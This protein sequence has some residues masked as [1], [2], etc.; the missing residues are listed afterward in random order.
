[1]AIRK[2][3]L[4]ALSSCEGELVGM[5]AGIQHGMNFLLI[6]GEI[7]QNVPSAQ[8]L[9]DTSAALEMVKSGPDSAFRTRFIL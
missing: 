2:H 7:A 5:V 1:M 8:V 9:N 4:T 3:N 6:V